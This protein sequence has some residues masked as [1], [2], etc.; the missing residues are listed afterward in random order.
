MIDIGSLETV[1]AD[2]LPADD[3]ADA[4]NG[5]ARRVAALRAGDP[6]RLFLDGRWSRVQLLWRSDRGNFLLFAGES[7]GETHSITRGAL[8]RLSAAGLVRPLEEL[9]LSRRAFAAVERRFGP[10]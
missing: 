10:R 6:L 7:I 3:A 4:G 5:P 8:E 9:S 1:P 2:L